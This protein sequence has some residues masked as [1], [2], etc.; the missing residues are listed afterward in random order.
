[1]STYTNIKT[2]IYPV[3]LNVGRHVLKNPAKYFAATSRMPPPHMRNPGS[4]EAHKNNRCYF[5][6]LL[7]F[8]SAEMFL[9][10]SRYM[11]LY[12]IP[13][14]T[15]LSFSLV[16]KDIS[17]SKTPLGFI[18]NVLIQQYSFNFSALNILLGYFSL[19]SWFNI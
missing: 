17:N 2:Q 12:N 8:T 18:T 6:T 11:S 15:P 5:F 14:L 10:M 4:T 1:M 19:K 13:P 16:E 7:E 9:C 3:T